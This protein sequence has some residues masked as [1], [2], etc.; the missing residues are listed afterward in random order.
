MDKLEQIINKAI[1]LPTCPQKKEAAIAARVWL[2]REIE[3]L[4]GPVVLNIGPGLIK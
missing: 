2:K 1:P 4:Y 3:R